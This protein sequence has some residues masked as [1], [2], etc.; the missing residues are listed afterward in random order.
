M[1]YIFGK[2]K[3][4]SFERDIITYIKLI[5][6]SS[7]EH[8]VLKSASI[9]KNGRHLEFS[10]P[11]STKFENVFRPKYIDVLGM[12]EIIFY[13]FPIRSAK[14]SNWPNGHFRYP[15]L[16]FGLSLFIYWRFELA[17]NIFRKLTKLSFKCHQTFSM[18][19]YR[20]SIAKNARKRCLRQFFKMAAI[21]KFGVGFLWNFNTLFLVLQR[22]TLQS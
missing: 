7:R 9:L 8:P 12:E 11:I 17:R 22:M 10:A 4:L 19:V 20:I 21:L 16:R 1:R 2:L 13:F 6:P 15:P 18:K 5:S 3:L 14:L